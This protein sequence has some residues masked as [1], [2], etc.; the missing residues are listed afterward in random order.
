MHRIGDSEEK[1]KCKRSEEMKW[2][3]SECNN[4]TTL[5]QHQQLSCHP[6]FASIYSSIERSE[7]MS[8]CGIY[9]WLLFFSSSG[10]QNYIIAKMML[11]HG[12]EKFRVRRVD[13]EEKSTQKRMRIAISVVCIHMW[14][15]KIV[16][17]SS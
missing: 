13:D 8:L 11:P 7:L 3:K 12:F 15:L 16:L 5:D 1:N 14:L 2:K 4:T 17:F 9:Q 6:A 10:F